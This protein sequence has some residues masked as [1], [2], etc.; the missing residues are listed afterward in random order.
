VYGAHRIGHG[1]R[2]WKDVSF[3][4]PDDPGQRTV[5]HLGPLAQHILD[6]QIHLEMAPTCNVQ[7]GAVPDLAHHPIAPFLRAGFNVGINTDNRLMSHVMPSSELLA[8]ATT[9][10][11]T[12]KEI[13]QLT[14]NALH[15]GFAPYETRMRIITEQVDPYFVDLCTSLLAMNLLIV[16][17]R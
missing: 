14:V 11:L 16:R 12:W 10:D 7:I 15:S 17:L 13:R 1:V 3:T 5:Q 8:V 6:R 2:L 9:F 4:A